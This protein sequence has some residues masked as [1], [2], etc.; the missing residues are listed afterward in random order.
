[1]VNGYTETLEHKPYLGDGDS[2]PREKELTQLVYLFF[3]A[4][5]TK[6]VNSFQDSLRDILLVVSPVAGEM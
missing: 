1:M 3:G 6:L 5:I 4:F 2:F